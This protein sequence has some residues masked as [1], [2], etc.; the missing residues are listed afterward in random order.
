ML[1]V[2]SHLLYAILNGHFFPLSRYDETIQRVATSGEPGAADDG[3]ETG[4]LQWDESRIEVIHPY[5]G[6]VRDPDRSPNTSPWGFPRQKDEVLP[7]EGNKSIRVAVFGGSV[8]EGTCR[9]GG[10]VL[11]STLKAHGITANILNMAIDGYKQPQQLIAL[12]YLLSHDVRPDVVV[13]IDGY[14]EVALSQVENVAVG[15]N[16]FYPRAWHV[17]TEGVHDQVALLQIGHLA[18]LKEKRHRW[19]AMFRDL[20]AFS[21]IRNLLWRSYDRPLEK[22]ITI[23]HNEI[24]NSRSHAAGGF[25]RTGP[26]PETHGEA[27]LYEQIA[28]HWVSCSLLMKGLCESQGIVYIHVLQPNQYFEEG[29][30][31]TKMEREYAFREDHP[32][33]PGVVKGY[34]KLLEVAG[35]LIEGGVNFHDLTMIYHDIPEPIYQDDCCHPNSF[36]YGIIANYISETIAEAVHSQPAGLH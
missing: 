31:L 10:T 36:G 5:L 1:E 22:R 18:V 17:R 11:Q 29:R 32:Y 33:R 21:I 9:D 35:E 13:N 15:V 23:A 2:C 30:T 8:A 7:E 16:P 24:L 3:S 14:N 27:D 34:P 28:T 6:F 25:L 26:D 4:R 19:A 20:P 12:A